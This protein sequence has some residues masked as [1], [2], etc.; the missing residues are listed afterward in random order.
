MDE[1][2]TPAVLLVDMFVPGDRPSKA[3]TDVY[4]NLT[5]TNVLSMDR[6]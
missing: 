1:T 4:E 2:G 6:H 3:Q 5:N